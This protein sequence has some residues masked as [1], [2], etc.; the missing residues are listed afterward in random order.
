MHWTRAQHCANVAR[1]RGGSFARMGVV[2]LL[3]AIVETGIGGAGSA[4]KA[5]LALALSTTWCFA[6]GRRRDFLVVRVVCVSNAVRGE[7][8]RNVPHVDIWKSG[9]SR[10]RFNVSEPCFGDQHLAAGCLPCM[11]L[12]LAGPWRGALKSHRSVMTPCLPGLVL[13]R[14]AGL[15][16]CSVLRVVAF[17]AEL[18]KC[19]YVTQRAEH[20]H[21]SGLLA[22]RPSGDPT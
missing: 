10:G 7:R 18:C 2:E 6:C 5:V 4:R 20:Q 19:T 21:S 17:V 14:A 16:R 3:G 8:G 15:P 9:E 22:A 12:W 13:P 1:C 11:V